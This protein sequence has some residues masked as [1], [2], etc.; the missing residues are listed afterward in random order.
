MHPSIYDHPNKWATINKCFISAT[1]RSQ[2][3]VSPTSQTDNNSIP[4][5]SFSTATTLIYTY[6][7][8]ITAA[9]GTKFSLHLLLDITFI[10]F[11]FQ[12]F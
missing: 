7:T 8:G 1:I 11:S 6:G 12:L 10:F 5:T 9:A 3:E 4:T 2:H